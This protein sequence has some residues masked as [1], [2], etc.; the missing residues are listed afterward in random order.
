MTNITRALFEIQGILDGVK[1]SSENP[2]FDSKYAGLEETMKALK[3]L[4]HERGILLSQPLSN[5]NGVQSIKLRLTHVESGET[6]E[7]ETVLVTKKEDPQAAGSSITYFRR[8]SIKS[9]F[10]LIDLDDDGEA[11]MCRVTAGALKAL[12]VKYGEKTGGDKD[13]F[14]KF[15]GDTLQK[16]GLGTTG[17]WTPD[18]LSLMT[19]KVEELT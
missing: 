1:K 8:Y 2:F 9:F 5:V 3:P 4:L 15:A 14:L 12:V 6:I 17:G 13:A 19:R 18:D 11:A 10:G 7:E 16:G